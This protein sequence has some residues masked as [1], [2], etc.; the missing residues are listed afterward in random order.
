MWRYTDEIHE[1]ERNPATGKLFNMN[2]LFYFF[3]QRMGRPI[4]VGS[5]HSLVNYLVYKLSENTELDR[6]K[7]THPLIKL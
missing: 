1:T 6:R 5:Y 7:C 3:F 4:E 2:H